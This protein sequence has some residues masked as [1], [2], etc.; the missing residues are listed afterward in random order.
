MKDFSCRFSN[1]YVYKSGFLVIISSA[2]N[3]NKNVRHFLPY[4]SPRNDNNALSGFTTKTASANWP[5]YRLAAFLVP[6]KAPSEASFRG[7][8]YLTIDLSKG[9][10]VLSTQESISLQFKTRQ[11]NGLLFYSGEYFLPRLG[12]T[13]SFVDHNDFPSSSD[14][15]STFGFSCHDT[16]ATEAM[17]PR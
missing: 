15:I 14:L 13:I 5:I 17:N 1:V 11:P 4:F 7:T 9:D 2:R 10:P 12:R 3:S 16:W 8:E 6:D